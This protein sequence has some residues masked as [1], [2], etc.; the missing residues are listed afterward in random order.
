MRLCCA[1]AQCDTIC[2]VAASSLLYQQN[3]SR[4]GWPHASNPN[5]LRA[6]A[7]R[8][9]GFQWALA[10][11]VSVRAAMRPVEGSSRSRAAVRLR[12]QAH[13][14][15]SRTRA[16]RSSSS[17]SSLTTT[18]AAAYASAPALL[19]QIRKSS[20]AVRI[21]GGCVQPLVRFVLKPLARHALAAQHAKVF[22]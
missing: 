10:G 4:C 18:A 3:C 11:P 21:G 15:L 17:S 19:T 22:L 1:S 2:S 9:H 20:F 14:A 16:A 7:L 8:A 6:H 5:R 12:P 13:R